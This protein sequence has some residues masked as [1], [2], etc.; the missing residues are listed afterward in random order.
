M[1]NISTD[2]D[3]IAALLFSYLGT[4]QPLML[5]LHLVWL[6]GVCVVLS[7]AYIVSFHTNELIAAYEQIYKLKC[8]Q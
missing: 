8:T 7:T 4:T 5:M 6:A 1:V 2:K 3:S